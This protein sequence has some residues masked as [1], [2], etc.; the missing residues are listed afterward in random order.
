MKNCT[1]RWRTRKLDVLPATRSPFYN[2]SKWGEWKKRWNDT[3]NSSLFKMALFYIILSV[4]DAIFLL[5]LSIGAELQIAWQIFFQGTKDSL[6]ETSHVPTIHHIVAIGSS[7]FLR[8]V[9]TTSSIS[10]NFHKSFNSSVSF[11]FWMLYAPCIIGIV[12][13]RQP[14]LSSLYTSPRASCTPFLR[15]V[16]KLCN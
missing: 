16:C 4:H 6:N 14:P 7:N 3:I 12:L 13:I 10:T 9:Y 5:A 2:N 11:Q 15:P 8:F 1:P